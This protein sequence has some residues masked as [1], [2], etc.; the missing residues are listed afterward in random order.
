MIN[1]FE[2]FHGAALVKLLHKNDKNLK[3]A[4]FD[5]P[6]NAS[7]VVNERAGL[8]IKHSRKRMSPWRFTFKRE[9]QDE[10][11][12]L[13]DSFGEVFLLLVCNN[14]GV[15]ALSYEELKFILN[16]F[17][18]DYEWVSIERNRRQEYGVKGSD[19]KLRWKIAKNEF[20]DKIINHLQ[21]S[22]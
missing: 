8:F 16:E 6:G 22:I 7:Y 18:K 1:E 19:G 4:T 15:V 12:A 17:H 5:S 9:H 11:Q 14:D 13:K 20:P 21:K 3:I 2:F 10:I